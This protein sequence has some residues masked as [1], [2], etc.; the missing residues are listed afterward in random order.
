MGIPK[1]Y[2]EA[3]RR[4]KRGKYVWIC[5]LMPNRDLHQYVRAH[6]EVGETPQDGEVTIL[7]EDGTVIRIPGHLW[8]IERRPLGRQDQMVDTIMVDMTTNPPELLLFEDMLPEWK[9]DKMR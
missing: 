9:P 3:W 8:V 2:R 1:I 4:T 6:N 7:E 5:V